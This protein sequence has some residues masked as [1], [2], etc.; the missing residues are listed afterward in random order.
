MMSFTSEA[1]SSVGVF[2]NNQQFNGGVTV[3]DATTFVGIRKFASAMYPNASV[4]YNYS[5]RTLTVK[6]D[7][8]YLTA[9]DG[10]NYI[11]ANGRYLYTES[12]VYMRYG[13]M[14]APVLLMAKAFDAKF[15]WSNYSSS[16]YIT[17]GSGGI[18]SGDKFYRS[19]EVLWLSR[20]I[21]A[22]SGAEPLVGKIAVGNV[23]LNRVR[24]SYFPNTIYGVIFDKKNGIQFSPISNGTIYN[25]PSNQSIIA[26]KICLEGYSV[27]NGVLYFVNAS[28]VPNSWVVKNRPLYAKIGNH[29][30]YY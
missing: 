3:K 10:E 2:I 14:Y 15:S 13:V 17:R 19:D 29:S 11:V 9:R 16:F 30:F 22:E 4:S 28:V 7:K 20:I 12:P 6:T 18:L 25:S 26:A 27:N 1:K 21:N 8:L 23:I 24:S 5:T